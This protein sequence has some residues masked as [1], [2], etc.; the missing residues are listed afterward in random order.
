VRFT[1]TLGNGADGVDP[2]RHT[3]DLSAIRLTELKEY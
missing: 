3:D 1:V 2:A